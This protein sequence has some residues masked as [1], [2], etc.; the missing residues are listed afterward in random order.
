MR[1]RLLHTRVAMFAVGLLLAAIGFTLIV[2]ANFTSPVAVQVTFPKTTSG[3]TTVG[4]TGDHQV[5][6][7][8]AG[9]PGAGIFA[10]LNPKT[11][12][13]AL[14]YPGFNA[15]GIGN[16]DFVYFF[17]V[18]NTTGTGS[19]GSPVFPINVFQTGY[20]TPTITSVGHYNKPGAN[21]T[22]AGQNPLVIP[23]LVSFFFTV[24]VVDPGEDSAIMFFTSPDPPVRQ[25]ATISGGG[26]GG[27]GGGVSSNGQIPDTVPP[28]AND[29][30]TGDPN[31]RLP[32]YGPCTPKIEVTKQV[33]CAD[34][35]N[36]PVLP[37]VDAKDVVPG[38]KVVY[39][40]TVKN[41][42]LVALGKVQ[43]H[44]TQLQI[45]SD[46]SPN[47]NLTDDF[48]PGTPMG[49]T[50]TAGQTVFKDFVRTVVNSAT[51]N[52]G[53]EVNNA[54]P[55]PVNVTSQYFIPNQ[56]G[57][58]PAVDP[59]CVPVVPDPATV[60]TVTTPDLTFHLPN[61]AAIKE[62]AATLD[63]P[64]QLIPD[65]IDPN[66]NSFTGFPIKL[67]YTLKTTNTGATGL[68]P[69]VIDDVKLKAIITAP[70]AGITV[71]STAIQGGAGF[72]AGVP[73]GGSFLPVTFALARPDGN[74]ATP[75]M[76]QVNVTLT[77]NNLAAY[78]SIADA[79]NQSK[80]TNT[81]TAS[82]LVTA[83][84]FCVTN[85]S[86]A[87]TGVFALDDEQ[88]M[89]MPPCS[90]SLTKEVACQTPGTFSSSLTALKGAS[91]IY[92]F[93]VTNNGADI[94]SNIKITDN[95][96]SGSP[97]TVPGTLNPGAS[98]SITVPAT[99][100]N[101]A[102]PFTNTATAT[103]NCQFASTSVTS[104]QASAT[105]NVLDPTI[106]CDKTVNG[107]KFVDPYTF[108][109]VLTYKLTATNTSSP[110]TGTNLNLTLNDPLLS[111]LPGVV[112]RRDD[113][114][115]VIALPFTFNNVPPSESRSI[116]CTVSFADEAA[117][118]AASG[119]GD[120]LVNNMTVN[121]TVS[122]TNIC[123]VGATLTQLVCN[124]QATVRISPPP[125]PPDFCIVT[126]CVGDACRG[127]DPGVPPTGTEVS[128]QRAGSILFYNLYTSSAANPAAENTRLNITNTAQG[129]VF[130]HLFFVDGRTCAVADSFIC[131][132]QN[133]TMAL[134]ASDIDPGIQGYVVAVAVG[135]DGCPIKW[136]YL[137]GDEYIKTANNQVANLAAEAFTA[138]AP[139]ACTAADSAVTLKLDGVQYSSAPRTL[140]V[141]NIFSALDNNTTRL[142]INRVGGDLRSSGAAVGPLFGLLFDDLETSHSFTDNAGCQFDRTLSQSFPRTTP[143]LN[144]VIPAGR[145]GWMK[146]W[147][148]GG[149][150]LL[151]V[152]LN[153]N[154]SAGSNS[155]AYSHG[156][157]LHK[158]TL[159]GNSEY[160]IPVF[161][162]N[163]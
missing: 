86:S 58:I 52:V 132:S 74:P 23:G 17:R 43:I 113:T 160:I 115:A 110:A 162:P 36:N 80:F 147:S 146:L 25:T 71:N 84:E 152:A 161:P 142:I 155:S 156:H 20:C 67:T 133:Q 120:V 45:A 119:G 100:P 41:T 68:S 28:N 73:T 102:G 38:S 131:L 81:M 83:G 39:R 94:L 61:I 121:G 144:T 79:S 66:K 56:D 57:T 93:T 106:G 12:G 54:A 137:I 48:F 40:I 138:I 153:F 141:D 111:S 114:N 53:T 37:F 85:A 77:I 150:G 11:D 2:R 62:V 78:Q 3:T 105:V 157:N 27:G 21:P 98:T 99:A 15:A 64:N 42:G 148:V 18:T 88:I 151:G 82:G 51:P 4:G 65:A 140:A 30:V 89:F 13:Q 72:A 63:S 128:D 75:T 104:N 70:P 1:K 145:S 44:D 33:A 26:G 34:D 135:T 109:N 69:V 125:P 49:G 112:C 6:R 123:V 76:G 154:S 118:R 8:N 22:T 122:D 19:N 96:L 95:K 91:L 149:N 87:A 60:P 97:F 92:R 136:N 108:G 32:V 163:P 47:G 127:N 10:A 129:T 35:S 14:F 16:N 107:V 126:P 9:V 116:T 130:V 7:P 55:P 50:L 159:G 90:I 59:P 31:R 29:P 134:T 124:S 101:V 143:R 46:N 5:A 24:D 158:L 103:A 117:F 139:P